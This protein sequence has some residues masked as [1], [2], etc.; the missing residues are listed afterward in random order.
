MSPLAKEQE[1]ANL[2]CRIPVG[3]LEMLKTIASNLGI[4]LSTVVAA[5][6]EWNLA[7]NKDQALWTQVIAALRELVGEDE[8]GVMLF[9]FDDSEWQDR[10]SNYQAMN[11]I[12]IIE[13]LRYRRSSSAN[14]WLCSFR[15]TSLGRI[16]ASVLAG[17]M[18]KAA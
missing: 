11:D 4:P 12:G 14:R 6:L 13:S 15:L 3:Q 2:Y 8:H 16:V 18:E 17:R 1:R 9:D 5:I 10:L 7:A